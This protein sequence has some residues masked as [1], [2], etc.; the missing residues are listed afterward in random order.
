[1]RRFIVWWSS[2]SPAAETSLDS[3]GRL[4]YADLPEEAYEAFDL[5]WPGDERDIVERASSMQEA[6]GQGPEQ[7]PKVSEPGPRV[8]EEPGQPS[9]SASSEVGPRTKKPTTTAAKAWASSVPSTA[10]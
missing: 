4:V 6:Q 10:T 5:P 9:S 2:A 7:A 1:M 8:D 3:E